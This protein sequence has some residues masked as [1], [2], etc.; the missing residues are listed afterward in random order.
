MTR[1]EVFRGLELVF[2][3][4]PADVS[5][6]LSARAESAGARVVDA[7]R[8]FLSDLT[9]PGRFPACRRQA[10]CGCQERAGCGCRGR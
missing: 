5:R 2:L 6:L 1:P 10:W 3:A 7:S 8:A 4:T 9:H